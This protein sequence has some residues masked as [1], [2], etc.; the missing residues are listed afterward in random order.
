MNNDR[1]CP[2]ILHEKHRNWEPDSFNL[3]IRRTGKNMFKELI[4]ILTQI[5]PNSNRK[6]KRCRKTQNEMGNE[7]N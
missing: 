7:L 4:K 5:L 6:T 2:P 1:N 3:N